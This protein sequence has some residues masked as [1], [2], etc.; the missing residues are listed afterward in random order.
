MLLISMEMAAGRSLWKRCKGDE[1][2]GEFFTEWGYFHKEPCVAVQYQ[3]LV[4]ERHSLCLPF[5]EWC[6]L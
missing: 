3:S 6:P 2:G 1:K 5:P 4:Q